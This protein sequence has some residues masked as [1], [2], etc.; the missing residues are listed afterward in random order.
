MLRRS[1]SCCCVVALISAVL[2][3]CEQKAKHN[4]GNNKLQ[5]PSRAET[6]QLCSNIMLNQLLLMWTPDGHSMDTR[7]TLDGHSMDTSM[8]TLRMLQ[9]LR[10]LNN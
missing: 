6:C 10:K 1:V 7:W 5:H 3:P 4:S 2:Q 8:D 9:K